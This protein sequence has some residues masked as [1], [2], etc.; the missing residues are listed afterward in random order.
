MKT[1]HT[2]TPLLR[3][4]SW[5]LI[6]F[7]FRF[8]HWYFTLRHYADYYCHTLI[9]PMPFRHIADISFSSFSH[10]RQLSSLRFDALLAV[11]WFSPLRHSYDFFSIRWCFFFHAAMLFSFRYAAFA[12]ITLISFFQIFLRHCW[13]HTYAAFFRHTLHWLPSRYAAIAATLPLLLR[14]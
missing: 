10:C 6:A 14:D 3:R 13:L 9:L 12:F 8:R 5:C 11:R 4:Q 2:I 7:R 1:L